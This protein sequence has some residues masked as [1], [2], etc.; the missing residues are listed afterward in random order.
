MNRGADGERKGS[1]KVE[2]SEPKGNLDRFRARRTK[3]HELRAL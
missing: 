2:R 3:P 1:V